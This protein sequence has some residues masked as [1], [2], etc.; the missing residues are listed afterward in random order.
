MMPGQ[1]KELD[2]VM[3]NVQTNS[4]GMRP[5]GNGNSVA[6]DGEGSA[7]QSSKGASIYK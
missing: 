7:A 1:F 5:A 2:D 3:Y 4:D 6:V